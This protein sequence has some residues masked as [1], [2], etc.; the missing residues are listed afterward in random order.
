MHVMFKKTMFGGLVPFIKGMRLD[1]VVAMQLLGMQEGRR[2]LRGRGR[3]LPPRPSRFPAICR[4]DDTNSTEAHI[5]SGE[6]VAVGCA[7]IRLSLNLDAEE[8]T[9]IDDGVVDQFQ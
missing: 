9:S 5:R 1:H 8:R 3:G 2:M 6:S 7:N 4:T